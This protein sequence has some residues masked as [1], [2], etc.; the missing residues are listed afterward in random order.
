MLLV[1]LESKHKL[2][3]KNCVTKKRILNPYPTGKPRPLRA[4][5]LATLEQTGQAYFTGPFKIKSDILGTARV[6]GLE[7]GTTPKATLASQAG[8]A[9]R[10]VVCMACGLGR[11]VE[12]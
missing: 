11:C 1:F 8:G 10:C 6:G 3:N 4:R 9:V 2:I 5:Q 7:L 12:A